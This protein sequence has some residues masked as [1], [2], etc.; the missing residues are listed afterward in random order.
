MRKYRRILVAVDVTESS[1][2]VAACGRML[3]AAL[4]ADLEMLTVVEPLPVAAPIPPEAVTAGLI[5]TQTTLIAAAREHLTR[6]AAA[7]GSQ[8][9]PWRV[10]VGNI[11]AEIV[12]VA[13]EHR[14]DLIVLGS[15]EKHGLAV[16]FGPTE[17]AVLHA[18]PCDVLAVRVA[19]EDA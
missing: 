1:V 17:D 5:E 13:R 4:G 16:I 14:A 2:K 12:R 8:P 11:K 19:P 7:A 18:A 6:L 9:V 3:A 10:E 15:H